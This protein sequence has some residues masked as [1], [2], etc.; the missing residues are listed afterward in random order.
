MRNQF[1][2]ATTLFIMSASVGC[3]DDKS[4]SKDN[5][6]EPSKAPPTA[7]AAPASTPAPTPSAAPSAAASSAAPAQTVEIQ[8]ASVANMMAYDKTKLSVP[9]GASVHLTLKNSA[10]LDVLPHNWVLVKPGTEAKVAA[11]GLAKAQATGYVVPGDDVL[12][13]TP[14]T[15]PGKSSDVTFTVPAPGDYPYIC[16]YP[17]HYIMMKGVLTVTP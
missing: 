4:P 14:L 5:N 9:T 7:S 10:T 6:R 2:V 3:N 15:P 11:A 1:I 16:T 13:Y 17:G 12:A 8:L